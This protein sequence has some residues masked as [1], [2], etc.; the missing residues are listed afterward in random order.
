MNNRLK[1]I[2]DIVNSNVND[3]M[4]VIINKYSEELKDYT[5]IDTLEKFSILPLKGSIKYINKYDHELR[6]GGLLIKIYEKEGKWY[7]VIKK[8]EK[9]YYISFSSN[10]IFYMENKNDI[11]RNWAKVFLTDVENGKYD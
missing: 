11:L 1:E 2:D 9:K 3:Y 7:G 5:F 6:N 4:N 8:L 10:Y